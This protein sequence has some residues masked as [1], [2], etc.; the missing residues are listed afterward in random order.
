MSSLFNCVRLIINAWYGENEQPS[1]IGDESW[2]LHSQSISKPE[3]LALETSKDNIESHN[4]LIISEML[5]SLSILEQKESTIVKKHRAMRHGGKL[6][7]GLSEVFELDSYERGTVELLNETAEEKPPPPTVPPASKYSPLEQRRGHVVNEI[8]K[9]EREYVKNLRD[10]YEGYYKQCQKTKD[11]FPH[12]R[13]DTLFSNIVDIYKTHKKLLN[14]LEWTYRASKPHLSE[15][16]SCFLDNKEG[17]LQYAV[18]CNNH[19]NALSEWA[20]LIVV[21]KYAYFFEVCRRHQHMMSLPFDGFLLMPVQKICKYP[22]LLTELLKAT[23]PEH[24]DYKN[25][26]A[27]VV[28]MKDV[29]NAINS[30]KGEDETEDKILKLQRTIL[31]WQGEDLSV[32]STQLLQRGDLIVI[33]RPR[34]RAKHVFALLFDHQMILCKKDLLK[35]NTLYF[36]ERIK[37]DTGMVKDLDDG[38]D[39]EFDCKVRNAIKVT[40]KFPDKPSK[41]FFTK[42]LADKQLWL[43]AFEEERQISEGELDA[44]ASY[45]DFPAL[46]VSTVTQEQLSFLAQPKRRQASFWRKFSNKAGS[47][48]D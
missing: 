25:V 33:P 30:Q 34:A 28:A 38:K 5:Q 18:Y 45:Y 6:I 43:H 20:K 15:F 36:K 29:L 13:M 8:I 41:L 23:P 26:E 14:C 46:N 35:R 16:G 42:N 47:G 10:I 44:D 19:V 1:E 48:K 7:R 27:A 40:S 3:S 31:N 24:R 32:M 17:F 12:A 37:M 21:E 2:E 11:L 39:V 9:S 22:L 4:N